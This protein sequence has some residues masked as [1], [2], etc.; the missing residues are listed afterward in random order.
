MAMPL[1]RKSDRFFV[2]GASG[3]VGSAVVRALKRSCYGEPSLGGELLTP[4]RKELNLLDDT[5]VRHWMTEKKTGC[6][7]LAAAT[8]GGIEANRNRPSDFLLENLRIETNVIEAAW[9][10]G[11]RR[12]LFL[13][14]SCIY[15]KFADQPIREESLLT[16]R[17]NQ[18]MLGMQLQKSPASSS[19]KPFVS[20]MALMRSA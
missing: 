10:A 15:P 8:V 9:R 6:V 11:V 17:L 19:A 1:I 14:S 12:L 18:P 20:S 4:S 13:G 5:A 2:A 16:E 7:V 3:M